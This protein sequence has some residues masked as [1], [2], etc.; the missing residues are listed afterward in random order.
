MKYLVTGG[1]GFV[2]NELVRQ[3]RRQQHEVAILDNR[4]RVAPRIEDLE[5]VPVLEVDITDT[6]GTQ[7]AVRR[8][9]PDFVIHLAAIHFI[10]ECNAHPERTL[11]VNVEGTL[12]VLRAAH[13]AGARK[14][15]AVSSGAVYADSPVALAESSLVAPVDI[16]G[17]SKKMAEDIAE[18]YHG[19]TGLPVIMVRL[20]NVFGPRETNAHIIPEII[21]QLR[22]SSTLRLG[23][24]TPRRDF[25]FTEDAAEGLW[26]LVQAETAPFLRVNLASGSHASVRELID[27]L[28][29]LLGRA[30]QVETDPTR[31]RQADKA[32][33]RSDIAL[34]ERLT[35]WRP[36]VTVEEGLR[37]L[38]RFES[39]LSG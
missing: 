6:A 38:L 3:L 13:G 36:R 22:S 19:S 8:V 30:I 2:G 26:R 24:I 1:L 7:A 18:W 16:Y 15:V 34:L 37:R 33:Q 21:G 17:H 29:R 25:I 14:V 39:L 27:H 28:G 5:D 12:A 31:F 9:R 23:N 20:F 32:I 11:R 4:N 35:G 10:P